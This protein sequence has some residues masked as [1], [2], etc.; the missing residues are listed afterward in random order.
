MLEVDAVGRVLKV[1]VRNAELTLSR[2]IG[3]NV[4][5]LPDA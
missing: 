4:W 5:V 3:E 2:D 1:G